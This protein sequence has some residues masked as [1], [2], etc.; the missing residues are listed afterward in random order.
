MVSTGNIA[1]CSVMPATAPATMCCSR[2]ECVDAGKLHH[3][4]GL[5]TAACTDAGLLEVGAPRAVLTERKA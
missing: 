3:A 4:A 1:V 2:M 5:C